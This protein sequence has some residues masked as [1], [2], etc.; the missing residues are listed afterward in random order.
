MLFKVDLNRHQGIVEEGRGDQERIVVDL[1][2]SFICK[3]P[4]Q[5]ND[6]HKARVEAA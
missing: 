2:L 1:L 5:N 6:W 4:S 3:W